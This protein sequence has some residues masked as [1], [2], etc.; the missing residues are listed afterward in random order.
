MGRPKINHEQIPLRFPAGIFKQIDA[1]L[2][3]AETRT[4]FIR[5][6]VYAELKRRK[7]RMGKQ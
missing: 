2:E 4:D 6:A 3:R 7:R 1:V 5:R